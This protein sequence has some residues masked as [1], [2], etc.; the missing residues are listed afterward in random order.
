MLPDLVGKDSGG[1]AKYPTPHKTG[2]T[3][4]NYSSQTVSNAEVERPV[5]RHR[6]L[7]NLRKDEERD[8][9]SFASKLLVINSMNSGFPWWLRGKESAC[10]SRRPGS[11]PELGRSL[12]EEKDN[13]LQGSRLENP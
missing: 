8:N 4:K 7:V 12:G 5:L 10:Q 11:T 1:G 3:T 13:P 9:S 6:I 2:S